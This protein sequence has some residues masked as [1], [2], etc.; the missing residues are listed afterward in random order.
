MR[1]VSK[2]A[3]HLLSL[4]ILAFL[5]GAIISFIVSHFKEEKPVSITLDISSLL[6]DYDTENA[7]KKWQAEFGRMSDE[8]RLFGA[9]GE[10]EIIY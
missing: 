8:E 4:L 6:V 2:I 5:M 9:V 1:N 7:E 3:A 10:P